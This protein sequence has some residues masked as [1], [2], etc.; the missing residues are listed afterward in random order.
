VVQDHA[1]S[2]DQIGG[3]RPEGNLEIVKARIRMV[4]GLQGEIGKKIGEPLTAGDGGG[5]DRLKAVKPDD[6]ESLLLGFLLFA[7]QVGPLRLLGEGEEILPVRMRGDA[8]DPGDRI[9]RRIQSADDAPKAVADDQIDGDVMPLQR[10][11]NADL[12]EAPRA[13]AAQDE[14]DLRPARI[15]IGPHLHPA[16]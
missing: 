14:P 6:E 12:C 13:A 16:V 1:L 7:E 2:A 9:P 5:D 4:G 15:S 10:L 11:E 3:G 8:L